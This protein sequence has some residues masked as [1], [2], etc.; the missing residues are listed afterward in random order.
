MNWF[1]QFWKGLTS[2]AP[3]S[4]RTPPQPV[5][6][7]DK[8]SDHGGVGNFS[9]RAQQV[10]ALAH[11]EADRFR[12]QF[13]G[14]E[15]VL[16]GLVA[17]NQ[18]VAVSVLKKLGL[19]LEQIR[20]EV[21]QQIGTG[22]DLLTY[23]NI[24][25]TPR[26]KRVLALADKERRSLGHTYVGTEHLFLGLLREGDGVA[27]R[28]LKQ[29]GLDIERARHEILRELDP[30][31]DPDNSKSTLPPPEMKPTRAEI[32]S[33]DT[34]KRYDIYCSERDHAVVVYRNARFKA[35]RK[36]FPENPHDLT[37]CYYEIEQADG[38]TVFVSRFSVVKFCEPGTVPKTEKL[39]PPPV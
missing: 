37:C 29:A 2:P 16:L 23:P 25:Y 20:R 30:N 35:L 34:S 36:L 39:P 11:R 7:P 17:L 6:L 18:G 8:V 4:R 3:V 1:K 22:P 32:E 27:A 9:P 38:T 26:L 15:H 13:V 33:V 10:L 21:E 12:H 19:D 24:P 31:L 5:P 28:V 14:T